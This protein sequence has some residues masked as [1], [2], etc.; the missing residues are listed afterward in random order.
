MNRK[1]VTVEKGTFQSPLVPIIAVLFAVA[2]VCGLAAIGTLFHPSSIPA[3]IRDM[4]V[5]QIYDTGA[6]M[7]WLVLYIAVT[8]VNSVGT[9]VLST[10]MFLVLSGRHYQGM[11]L[12]YNSAKG[13]RIALIGSG[14]AALAYFIF[15]AV[16]YTVLCLQS[17]S[18]LVPLY[19]MV[20]MEGLMLVL[21]W[22]VFT[23]LRQFLECSIDTV[24]SIGYT[25]SAGKLNAPTIPAFSAIGFLIFAIVDVI[26]AVDRF[27][28]F[29]FTQMNLHLIFKVPVST[30]PVQILSG[31]SLGFAAIGGVLMFVY[32]RGYKRKS[33]RLL[34]HPTEIDLA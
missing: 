32:L 31:L 18:G 5:A 33:E 8:A 7:T 25:L 9:L 28:T 2:A 4:E 22:V 19:A 16:R 15:R 23:K 24:A 1:T 6:Q 10:G 13:L 27:I 29:S 21:A 26:L 20:V 30:D 3:V 34:L 12:L 17:I 14:A 11:D